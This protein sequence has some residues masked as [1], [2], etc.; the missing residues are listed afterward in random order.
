MTNSTTEINAF[1]ENSRKFA[2]PMTRLQALSARTFER[3]ARYGYEVAG[4]YLN[5]SLASLHAA[6]QTHELPAL[7]KKQTEL[8]T[9][10]VEKQT[11]R[12]QDF[13][14]LAGE[15]QADV[16]QWVDHASTEFTARTKAA[17]AA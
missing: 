1:L 15:A 12:S 10:Y 5:L 13:L 14:K 8:T 3:F 2:E 17:K 7:L 6:T 16:T 9:A 4:D 11:Q